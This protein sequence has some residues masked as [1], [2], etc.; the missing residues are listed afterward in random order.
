MFL[1]DKPAADRAHIAVVDVEG[2]ALARRYRTRKGA[3]EN[4]L[5]GFQLDVVR[6]QLV[7]Q[8]ATPLAG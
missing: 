6:R 4:N 8:P 5:S 7:R 3:A 1:L 2:V